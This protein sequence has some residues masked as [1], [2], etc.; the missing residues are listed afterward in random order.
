M[1]RKPKANKYLKNR[2]SVPTSTVLTDLENNNNSAVETND[3]KSTE[4][5]EDDPVNGYIVAE[6][7]EPQ[8]VPVIEDIVVSNGQSADNYSE[9]VAEQNLDFF[10][11][12]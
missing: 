8:E 11:H 4:T 6:K 1:V 12:F 3:H 9:V 2:R 7:V 5:E 10:F